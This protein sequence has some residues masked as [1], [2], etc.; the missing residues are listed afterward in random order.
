MLRALA[1]QSADQLCIGARSA[2]SGVPSECITSSKTR[3]CGDRHSDVG[4]AEEVGQ[5]FAF[6]VL[7]VLSSILAPFVSQVTWSRELA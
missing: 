5:L 2:Q 7:R 4:K 3:A 6:R 1:T